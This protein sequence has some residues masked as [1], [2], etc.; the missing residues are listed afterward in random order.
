MAAMALGCAKD[1]RIALRV[2]SPHD[3]ALRTELEVAFER[4]HP[5]VDVEWVVLGSQEIF[6]RV[7]AERAAPAADVW[8]GAPSDRF[9]AAAREGLLAT[10]DERA[11]GP[12]TL[13]GAG[14]WIGVYRSPI[15]LGYNREVLTEAT[16][17]RGWRDLSSP[18]W[19]GRVVLRDPRHSGSMQALAAA[20]FAE[21]VARDG[22]STLAAA[23]LAAVDRNVRTY[24]SSPEALWQHL[25][26]KD[27]VVTA[28]NLTELLAQAEKERRPIAWRVPE[29]GVPVLVDGIAVVQGAAHV[30]MARTFVQYVTSR[31]ASA[32]AA[33]RHGRWPVRTD[34]PPGALPV[35]TRAA[36]TVWPLLAVRAPVMADSMDA[37]MRPWTAR[38]ASRPPEPSPLKRRPRA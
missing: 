32:L 11:A 8:F 5:D 21:A 26:R 7:R 3:V 18:V 4:A 30:A 19:R 25:T 20:R 17:P 10:L 28:W 1:S 35:W 9:I 14:R 15:V 31:E 2:Y 23:W 33:Q 34:V 27:G 22:S 24:V 13:D 29:D 16:A 37:W 38:V 12:D 6:D 36:S